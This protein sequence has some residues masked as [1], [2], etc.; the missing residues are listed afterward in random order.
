MDGVRLSVTVVVIFVLVE[1]MG[2][3]ALVVTNVGTMIM[4]MM[5]TMK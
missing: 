2:I 3:L 4:K 1:W 5:M